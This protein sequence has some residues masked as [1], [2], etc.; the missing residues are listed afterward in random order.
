MRRLAEFLS[1]G[2]RNFDEK[3][4]TKRMATMKSERT[5]RVAMMTA[6]VEKHPVSETLC[7]ML[8]ITM[9]EPAGSSDPTL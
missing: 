6:A 1:D 7:N 4:K 3:Q 2:S 5:K 8:R 9:G